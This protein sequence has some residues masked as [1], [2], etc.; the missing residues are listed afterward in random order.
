M[1]E[2]LKMKRPSE[3]R[4]QQQ[5]QLPQMQQQQQQQ[6]SPGIKYQYRE[7]VCSSLQGVPSYHGQ[8]FV[9]IEIEVAL[10]KFIQG[11]PGGLALTLGSGPVW[12]LHWP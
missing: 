4:Q 10:W 6:A 1:L 12:L 5:Q 8:A 2:K 7:K 9:D 11:D 3:Q